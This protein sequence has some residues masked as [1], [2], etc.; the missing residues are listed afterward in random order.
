M[1]ECFFF[2]Y[3]RLTEIFW[4]LFQGLLIKVLWRVFIWKISNSYHSNS[5]RE[6]FS[7]LLFSNFFYEYLHIFTSY[8]ILEDLSWAYHVLSS[9]LFQYKFQKP[10]NFMQANQKKCQFFPSWE[11]LSS[12]FQKTQNFNIKRHSYWNS[13][14]HVIKPFFIL[15]QKLKSCLLLSWNFSNLFSCKFAINQ[16]FKPWIIFFEFF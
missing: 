16:K 2:V 10:L 5:S 14:I 15:G 9:H 3:L 13:S 1:P 6:K 7:V 11:F 4:F 12:N 8:C